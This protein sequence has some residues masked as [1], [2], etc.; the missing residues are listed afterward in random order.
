MTP[1]ACAY[2]F[3]DVVF[4]PRRHNQVYCTSEHCR[5][6]TN[7]RLKETYHNA[8]ARRAGKQRMCARGCGTKL[9]RYNET[10]ICAKCEG[11][12]RRLEAERMYKIYNGDS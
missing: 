3:C 1:I 7:I 9:S 2:R 4:T 5:E 6:E 12:D 10:S 8:K 11:Q